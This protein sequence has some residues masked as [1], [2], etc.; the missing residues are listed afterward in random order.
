MVSS[1]PADRT[2]VLVLIKGLGIGGA[3]RLIAEGAGYWDRESI[4]YRVAY[5]LP[6]KDQLVGEI[7]CNGDR[8]STA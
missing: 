2:R 3:E 6:W 1:T 7:A 8:R 5:F 4:D